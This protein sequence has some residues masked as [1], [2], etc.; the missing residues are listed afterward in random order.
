[1]DSRGTGG[2]FGCSG[3]RLRFTEEVF[4]ISLLIFLNERNEL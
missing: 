3:S 4:I 1:M 2:D